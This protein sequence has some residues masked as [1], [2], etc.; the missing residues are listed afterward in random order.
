MSTFTE[1][2]LDQLANAIAPKV[3][4]IIS[5][6]GLYLDGVM[7]SMPYAIKEVLESDVSPDLIGRLG[8]RIMD[9][10][11]IPNTE[12]VDS[13]WKRRYDALYR[14]VKT[15]FTEDYIEGAEYGYVNIQYNGDN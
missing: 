12:E 1:E 13:V 9:Q 4:A 8:A 6:D 2:S 3:F 15:N 14:Y 7:N 11:T 10:I 5:E